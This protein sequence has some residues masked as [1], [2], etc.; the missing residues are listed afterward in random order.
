[1]TSSEFMITGEKINFLIGG[2]THPIGDGA[3]ATAVVLEID[4]DIV[5]ESTGSNTET[6]ARAEWDVSGFKGN[7]AVIKIIDENP[8]G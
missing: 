6:M 5:L 2:G 4:G 3:G 1:M 7:L 8:G